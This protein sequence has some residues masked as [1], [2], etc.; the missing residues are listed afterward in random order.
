M[1]NLC[2]TARSNFFFC[3]PF[4]LKTDIFHL[5]GSDYEHCKQIHEGKNRMRKW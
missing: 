5:I 2:H 1:Y 3:A 4:A